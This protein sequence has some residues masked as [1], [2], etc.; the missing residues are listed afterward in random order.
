MLFISLH[1]AGTA[2]G[3]KGYCFFKDRS[4]KGKKAK[5]S[6]LRTDI[7]KVKHGEGKFG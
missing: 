7:F 3:K 1:L 2:G 5:E 4:E 6:K